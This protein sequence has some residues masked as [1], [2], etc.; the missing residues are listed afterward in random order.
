MRGKFEAIRNG[1]LVGWLWNPKSPES[2]VEF[3]LLVN[4]ESVGRFTAK[5]PRRDLLI[6]KIGNGEHAFK[7]P[8]D[9]SWV[10]SLGA[11]FSLRTETPLDRELDIL[12]INDGEQSNVNAGRAPL[13]QEGVTDSEAVGVQTV[14]SSVVG[15]Q[16]AP[17]LAERK[18]VTSPGKTLRGRLERLEKNEL[19]GWLWDPTNAEPV[20]FKLLVNEMTVGEYVADRRRGD[21]ARAGIGNGAHGFRIR[22]DPKWFSRAE[23]HCTVLTIPELVRLADRLIVAGVEAT[24]PEVL[25]PSPEEL[26]NLAPPVLPAVEQSAALLPKEVAAQM[27]GWSTA[28]LIAF[29]QTFEKDLLLER[30]KQLFRERNW[31]EL[32]KFYVTALPERKGRPDLDALIGRSLL[33][34]RKAAQ[35]A[36]V[37]TATAAA[38]PDDATIQFYAAVASGR[39]DDNER[40]VDLGR[41]ALMLKPDNKQYLIDHA[42]HCR[43]HAKAQLADDSRRK[44]LLVESIECIKRAMDIDTTR[45]D[46]CL[47]T[48]A[49]NYADLDQFLLAVATIEKLLV[50]APDHIEGMLVLSQALVSLN[51]IKQ[52]LTVAERILQIDPLRQAPRFLLRS[53]GGL[54]DDDASSPPKFG[55]AVW[56]R[57]TSVITVQR[58]TIVDGAADLEVIGAIEFAA[59]PAMAFASL[60]VDWLILTNDSAPDLIDPDVLA[61]ASQSAKPRSGRI[62]IHATDGQLVTFW[63]RQLL[64]GLAESSLFAGLKDVAADL[65]K[66]T[67]LVDTTYATL[68]RPSSIDLLAENAPI[69][70][71]PAIAMS[72]HGIVKFGG[73]EQF[74]DSMAEHYASMGFT[75]IIVGTRD[76]RIGEEGEENGRRYAFVSKSPAAI[77]AYFLRVRPTIVHV[78]SGLGYE[79]AEALDYLN[80]P[81]IYGVH[82][83]RDCLGAA[84]ADHR[85]FLDHDRNPVPRP[86]FRYVIETAATV[87]ANSE[88][89]RA[90]LEEAFALRPPVIY[91]LPREAPEQLPGTPDQVQRELGDC[92]NYI[93]LVNA[94]SDK[95]FDLIIDVAKAVPQGL[96]VA[97][98]SQSDRTEAEAAVRGAGIGN[99]RI[100]NHTRRMDI[101]YSR[102]KAVAVPSYAFVETF[103]RVCIEAQRFGKPVLGSTIGN[104]PYLLQRSGIVLPENVRAWADEIRRLYVDEAYYETR[105]VSAR[106]NSLLYSYSSQQAALEGMLSNVTGSILIGVGSGIGNMLHLTPMI[107]NISRRLDRKI[108]L[109]MTED[110]TS[111]LFLLQNDAYVNSVYSVRPEVLRRRY[112]TVF[113]THSFGNARLPFNA[114]R[115]V[116]SR[117]WMTFEPAGPFHET[118]YNLEAT[119]AVLGIPYDEADIL[120]YYLGNFQYTRRAAGG[121]LRI[122][123]HGGSKDGFWR[124]KRWPGHAQLAANLIGQGHRVASF[125]IAEE[126]VPG[127][128]DQTGG[129]IAEMVG[130]MLDLD[131]F[132][133]NDS[134][135]MNI[136]NALGIPV[137]GLFAPTNGLTRG[138]IGPDSRWL[139]ITK[140][141]SPC[142]VTSTGR[143]T[144]QS[145]NCACIAELPIETV[146]QAVL[147]HMRELGMI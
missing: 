36:R 87:Y 11:A 19:I 77:R 122:G 27:R 20:T 54:V 129:T 108:D 96:F 24:V 118:V 59:D 123:V 86:A 97:I 104:V 67:E 124:S 14:K 131:Y 23:N 101:V 92:R 70:R 35:A 39:A 139:A 120:G 144:F 78:L 65:S 34:E 134:G 98:A 132:I 62:V 44:S 10:S 32:S 133:S 25:D 61:R 3:D 73:G 125:G 81:F 60:D 145:S 18:L 126:Y 40:A 29:Q 88:Y 84:E 136:A 128:E 56:D 135:L 26:K 2:P 52:A 103:S 68:P 5:L 64:V 110:H 41:A 12:R 89:T 58:T 130:K 79:V 49:R 115:V 75:P 142:E 37:L 117:D 114:K 111:S 102:A 100:I 119:K 80:I 7:I 17:H 113:I 99:L 13:R 38:V 30:A 4:G 28:R 57:A 147:D 83:W 116:Y 31:D 146:E 16:T 72:R 8:V 45:E 141:C 53:L 50:I 90:I 63:R 46:Y 48:M 15:P 127:T 95:G 42:T 71:G 143:A 105:C 137:I 91:S 33:Y 74:L 107:R 76:D 121:A 21:L 51:R 140:D 47:F 106:E 138:P 85:F 43:R 82:F 55:I 69:P 94:K 9:P 93:L 66:V 109:V 112:D 6:N 22:T 1:S